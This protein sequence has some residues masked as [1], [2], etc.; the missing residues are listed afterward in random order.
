MAWPVA[1][2]ECSGSSSCSVRVGF[3]LH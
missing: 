1:W 2:D 3:F